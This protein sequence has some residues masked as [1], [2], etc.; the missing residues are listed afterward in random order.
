M[1][2][3]NIT[4]PD[5]LIPVPENSDSTMGRVSTTLQSLDFTRNYPFV[6]HGVN[7]DIVVDVLDASF[8]G[9]KLKR[10]VDDLLGAS[11]TFSGINFYNL[12][13]LI[14]HPEASISAIR[15]KIMS[16]SP[17]NMDDLL[18]EQ[19][20]EKKSDPIGAIHISDGVKMT[21]KRLVESIYTGEIIHEGGNRCALRSWEK[22]TA[23]PVCFHFKKQRAKDI[24]NAILLTG[25]EPFERLVGKEEFKHMKEEDSF[26]VTLAFDDFFVFLWDKWIRYGI[27]QEWIESAIHWLGRLEIGETGKT[28]AIAAPESPTEP[29]DDTLDIRRPLN[30]SKKPLVTK[31]GRTDMK[32]TEY[33]FPQAKKDDIL[34]IITRWADGKTGIGVNWEPMLPEGKP[35]RYSVDNA[36]A[37]NDSIQWNTSI[38]EDGLGFVVTSVKENSRIIEVR[39]NDD[40]FISKSRDGG[41]ILWKEIVNKSPI[42]VESGSI[43]VANKDSTFHQ[44]GDIQH[45]YYLAGWNVKVSKSMI[46]GEVVWEHHIGIGASVLGGARIISREG[47]VLIKKDVNVHTNSEIIA[48]NGTVLIE[49]NIEHTTIKADKI[50]VKG[51]ATWCTLVGRDVNVAENYGSTIA[52]ETI[53]VGRDVS[54]KK[55]GSYIILV[56]LAVRNYAKTLNKRVKENESRYEQL[57]KDWDEKAVKIRYNAEPDENKKASIKAEWFKMQKQLK[58]WKDFLERDRALLGSINEAFDQSSQDSISVAFSTPGDHSGSMYILPINFILEDNLY[59]VINP[60]ISKEERTKR[61]AADYATL[62]EQ[63]HNVI[64]PGGKGWGIRLVPEENRVSFSRE[65][66]V[67][68]LEEAFG[69]RNWS[70]SDSM[71]SHREVL[72]GKEDAENFFSGKWLK[73]QLIPPIVVT[74]EWNENCLLADLSEKWSAFFVPKE[75]KHIEKNSKI[76]VRYTLANGEKEI[77]NSTAFRVV[78]VEELSNCIKISGEYTD[79]WF[80]GI[81]AKFLNYIAVKKKESWQG[82]YA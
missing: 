58:D 76:S 72:L 7:G 18:G 11:Y 3:K 47:S 57:E 45:G 17:L 67:R 46:N 52:A 40:V 37:L 9:E 56:P 33:S 54:E 73:Q 60:S 16:W 55:E 5:F 2:E 14:Y 61:K 1:S 24:K 77:I 53:R 13:Q 28:I 25:E 48:I 66:C 26:D 75:L 50:I 65:S 32:R 23:K 31:D 44:V 78:R 39:T 4:S 70:S 22:S 41:Y 38:F 12:E 43:E 21:N 59:K 62:V 36:L 81:I 29:T 30:T 80:E 63:L 68:Q 74:I 15:G 35:I 71:E 19:K 34:F 82:K 79:S 49:G 69:Q 8:S 51:K 10:F 6:Q 20:T 42:G 27:D 64:S